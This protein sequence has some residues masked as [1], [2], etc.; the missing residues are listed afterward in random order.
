MAEIDIKPKLLELTGKNKYSLS[1]FRK[2]IREEILDKIDNGNQ[3]KKDEFISQIKQGDDTYKLFQR[4]ADSKSDYLTKLDCVDPG[5]ISEED[6]NNFDKVR[7]NKNGKI[8]IEDFGGTTPS[9]D[10]GPKALGADYS[11]ETNKEKTWLYDKLIEIVVYREAGLD[12]DKV[13]GELGQELISLIREGREKNEEKMELLMLAI[14]RLDEIDKYGNGNKKISIH[15]VKRFASKAGKINVLDKDDFDAPNDPKL[16]RYPIP[17]GPHPDIKSA[18]LIEVNSAIELGSKE[19]KDGT[20]IRGYIDKQDE[21]IYLVSY[22]KDP[23]NMD[24]AHIRRISIPVSKLATS[25]LYDLKEEEKRRLSIEINGKLLTKVNG[26]FNNIIPTLI[27][28]NQTSSTENQKIMDWLVNEYFKGDLST[29]NLKSKNIDAESKILAS[30]RDIEDILKPLNEEVNKRLNIISSNSCEGWLKD[31]LF[32]AQNG[33]FIA[34]GRRIEIRKDAARQNLVRAVYS[35]QDHVKIYK[36][37]FLE[38][39]CWQLFADDP[40]FAARF[41]GDKDELHKFIT[42]I[43]PKLEKE[44]SFSV[45]H[46]SC[47]YE[48]VIQIASKVSSS[49]S[50]YSSNEI[51]DILKQKSK[52]T[53]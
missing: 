33:Y 10:P 29:E 25:A 35:Y 23:F 30:R 27:S 8:T 37:A 42:N 9:L 38:L 6:I 48:N 49:P 5:E 22:T 4:L 31:D 26:D 17:K 24:E 13:A 53:N 16:A 1:D 36:K 12:I 14:K 15:E 39:I 2:K 47:D 11:S 7:G 32:V 21:K 52:E 45:E 20:I 44:L 19:M 18:K 41:K 46:D 34:Q 50:K 51:R 43:I 3:D 28:S 40:E